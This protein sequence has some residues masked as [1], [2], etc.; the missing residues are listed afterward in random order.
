MA[1]MG[2]GRGMNTFTQGRGMAKMGTGRGL[3]K[4]GT[5]RGLAKMGTGRGLAKMGTGRG[6]ARNSR[7]RGFYRVSPP[8][9]SHENSSGQNTNSINNLPSTRNIPPTQNIPPSQDNPRYQENPRYQGHLVDVVSNY[10]A[11]EHS[12]NGNPEE[13]NK[14]Q[15]DFQ[16]ESVVKTMSDTVGAQAPSAVESAETSVQA[17]E[18]QNR[19]TLDPVYALDLQSYMDQGTRL[20]EQKSYFEASTFFVMAQQVEGFKG[21]ASLKMAGIRIAM[22]RYFEG[23]NDLRNFLDGNG[24]ITANGIGLPQDDML[25]KRLD[26]HV[27]MNPYDGNILTSAILYS[28]NQSNKEKASR[29]HDLLISMDPYHACIKGLNSAIDS[30]P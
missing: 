27:R 8:S 9:P 24:K 22:G 11:E 1:K 6:M 19:K 10:G 16:K 21:P 20:V 17:N 7:N 23:I 13:N 14:S 5:G 26:D 3:A 25:E 4:T 28:I 15:T 29:L 30:M 18:P 12:I 2:T